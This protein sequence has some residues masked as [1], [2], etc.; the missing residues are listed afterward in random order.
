M[1]NGCL[2]VFAF[3]AVFPLMA[4]GHHFLALLIILAL[5]DI[6]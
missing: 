3:I 6:L 1:N 4:H 5:L 2:G